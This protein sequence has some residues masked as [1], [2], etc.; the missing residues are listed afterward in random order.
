M[1]WVDSEAGYGLYYGHAYSLLDVG[2]IK[3]LPEDEKKYDNRLIKCRNPW[4]RGEWEG[5]FSD[6]SEER[7]KYD[8]ELMRVF[9]IRTKLSLVLP[10]FY[11]TLYFRE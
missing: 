10:R 3:L 8:A 7:H 4:G 6:N 11:P 9:G 1:I 5:L 2:T